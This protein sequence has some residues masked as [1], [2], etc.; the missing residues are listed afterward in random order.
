MKK[1]ITF[2]FAILLFITIS[3]SC[4]GKL[5]YK[6]VGIGPSCYFEVPFLWQIKNVSLELPDKTMNILVQYQSKQCIGKEV[7]VTANFA[8]YKKS[9]N[10]DGGIK[11]TIS[12]ISSMKGVSDFTYS[13]S[14]YYIKKAKTSICFMSYISNNK[15]VYIKSLYVIPNNNPKNFYTFSGHYANEYSQ[16]VVDKLFASIVIE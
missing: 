5:F 13:L 10:I 2:W 15:N 7:V 11:E 14:D 6:K 4:N 3:T 8:E 1:A 9:A 12:Q 16:E